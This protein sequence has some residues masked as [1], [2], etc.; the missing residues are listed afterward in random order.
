MKKI[1][2]Y[3][4]NCLH[5]RRIKYN[6]FWGVRVEK[7]GG[8]LNIFYKTLNFLLILHWVYSLFYSYIS[9]ILEN[10]WLIKIFVNQ[11]FFLLSLQNI[12]ILLPQI[13][14]YYIF[15]MA[16]HQFCTIIQRSKQRDTKIQLQM[17]IKLPYQI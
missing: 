10:A 12:L 6:W 14:I 4:R 1:T 2:K 5:R 15:K 8:K 11:V 7:K 3:V 16:C 17:I 9:E 13:K